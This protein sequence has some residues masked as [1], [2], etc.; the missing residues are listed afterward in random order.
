MKPYYE[1]DRATLYNADALA[2]LREL[3]TAS[4]G[5][6]ITDPPYSSGGMVRGDRTQAGT[7][8][9]YSGTITDANILETF[10]GDSRDQ[11]AYAYW[12]ALWLAE[13]ARVVRPGGVAVV[14]T[15]WRQAHPPLMPCSLAAGCGGESSR[16]LRPPIARSQAGSPL[17]AS[18][19][20]GA[21][22]AR[23]PWITLRRSSQ[24]SSKQ[25]RLVTASTSPRSRL[26]SCANS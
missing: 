10:T 26:M 13:A 4:V 3:P 11:R 19:P 2:V 21:V 7:H 8:R 20:Y 6:L 15:D 12:C 9:K 25:P 14:F 22:L 5:A 16:G 24:G 17:S 1:D 18:T 23:C